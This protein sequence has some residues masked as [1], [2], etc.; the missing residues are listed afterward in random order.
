MTSGHRNG[1]WTWLDAKFLQDK[2][3]RYLQTNHRVVSGKL[4]STKLPLEACL[5]EDAY[6]DLKFNSQGLATTKSATQNYSLGNN[7]Q[8]YHPRD[9]A[10]ARFVANSVRARLDCNGDPAYSH[11]GL[12]VFSCAEG[13][14]QKIMEPKK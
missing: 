4:V 3:S 12:G 1:C 9:G 13:T 8:F 5:R 6:V 14:E 10:V 2:G 7:I 11:A